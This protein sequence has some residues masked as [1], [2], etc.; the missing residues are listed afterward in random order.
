MRPRALADR[1]SRR[2]TENG[3]QF[4]CSW[5]AERTGAATLAASL[6]EPVAFTVWV[7]PRLRSTS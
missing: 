2:R 1:G 4:R 7:S 5:L 6:A 3:T